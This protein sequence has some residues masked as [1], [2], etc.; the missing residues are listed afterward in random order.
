MG[1]EDMDNKVTIHQT[2]TEKIFKNK[3]DWPQVMK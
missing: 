2:S 3:N 1:L